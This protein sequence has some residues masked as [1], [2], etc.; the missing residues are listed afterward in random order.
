MNLDLN[1]NPEGDATH[2]NNYSR[3]AIRR[4]VSRRSALGLLGF[5]AT[6]AKLSQSCL[7]SNDRGMAN[8]RQL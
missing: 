6:D 5:G 7:N 1:I 8:T 2:N 3:P 4:I